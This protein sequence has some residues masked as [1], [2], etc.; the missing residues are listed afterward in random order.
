[1]KRKKVLWLG[2]A[3]LSFALNALFAANVSG[4]P[5]ASQSGQNNSQ[6]AWRAANSG[7][8]SVPP[9]NWYR[10]NPL[11]GNGSPDADSRDTGSGGYSPGNSYWEARS[12]PYGYAPPG[13]IIPL[14]LITGLS[15]R[16]AR[17][18]D[19]V[20]ASVDRN[21]TLEGNSYI[22]AGS[23]VSGKVTAAKGSGF[24]QRGG[25]LSIIFNELRQPNGQ[26]Y[27]LSAHL[28][29]G[30]GN[31][32]YGNIS[33]A[34]AH[35]GVSTR[36]RLESMGVTEELGNVGEAG[37]GLAAAPI[38]GTNFVRGLG[39]AASITGAADVLG[40]LLRRGRNVMVS[41]GMRFQIQ[42]DSPLQ[43]GAAAAFESNNSASYGGSANNS[44]SSQIPARPESGF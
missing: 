8:F 27:G 31:V 5:A 32:G 23:I 44:N 34:D 28:L 43:I 24:F 6:P 19:P 36:R 41:S 3:T 38:Y 2:L 21:I 11:S 15:S 22:P 29:G 17:D 1:M 4:Q 35:G 33:Y 39:S 13:M 20:R 26:S 18:G 40:G 7:H 14:V 30:L 16:G 10:Y 25:T 12:V 9:R 37:I 42:L